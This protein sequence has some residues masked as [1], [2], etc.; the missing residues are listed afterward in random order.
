MIHRS[1]GAVSHGILDYALAIMLII[2]PSV[3]GFAGVKATWAYIFG[4]LLFALALVTRYPLGVVKIIGL[5]LHGFVELL[6]I[7][8]V[9]AAP[10]FGSFTSGVTSPRFYWM[11]GLLMLVLWAITD[12]RGVRGR[13]PATPLAAPVDAPV[14]APVAAPPV[15]DRAASPKPKAP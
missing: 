4:G 7:A 2:G 15:A 9:I 10:W 14:A 12:F 13:V 8:C 6:L 5:A 11:M 3:A 1:I